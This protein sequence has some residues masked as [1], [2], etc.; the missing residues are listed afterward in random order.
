MST[1]KNKTVIIAGT[2]PKSLG[3]FI[4]QDLFERGWDVWLYSRHAKRVEKKSWHERR[5]DISSERQIKR[6][7][8]Q[9]PRVD[10]CVFSADPDGH[11]LLESL[12]EKKVK[13]FFGAKITGSL[14]MIK[15][16]LF[17]QNMRGKKGAGKTKLIWL[18]GKLGVKPGELA[19]YAVANGGIVHT[20]NQINATE[21]NMRAYTLPLGVISPSTLGDAYMKDH[22]DQK[23]VTDTPASVAKIVAT[24]LQGGG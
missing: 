14:L 15:Q 3:R 2:K 21:K 10:A 5:L 1:R 20:M 12:S 9:I 24:I 8:R 22:P 11:G 4:G 16:L 7:L 23:F 13:D 17:R 19:L 6:F 18:T